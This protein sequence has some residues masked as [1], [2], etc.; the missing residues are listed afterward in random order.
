MI[1]IILDMGHSRDDKTHSHERIVAIAARRIRED[2]TVTPGVAEIMS[3]A[4]LTHGGFYKHFGSRD[5]LIAEAVDRTFAESSHAIEEVTAGAEL[6]FA[7]FVD[8]YVSAEHRDDPGSG[9]G[10]VALGADAGHCGDR[11]RT[12]YTEQVKRYLARLE[13]LQGEAGDDADARARAAVT[14]S[15]LVGAVLV[16]RA[17]NDPEL[18]DAILRDVRA[19]LTA[20]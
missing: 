4:G 10:V 7:A 1:D 6:P 14:L 8:W 9:C 3:A 15:T 2:G 17:V 18:S 16:A 19:A 20:S 11:V 12:A 13:Q 5:D